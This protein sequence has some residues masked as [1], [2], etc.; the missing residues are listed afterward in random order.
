MFNM[1][2]W[3]LRSLVELYH[4]QSNGSPGGEFLITPQVRYMKESCSVKADCLLACSMFL[5]APNIK[6]ITIVQYELALETYKF[7]YD[8]T[9]LE[10]QQIIHSLGLRKDTCTLN[11]I[12]DNNIAR[13]V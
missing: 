9:N 12:C 2:T 3:Y 8:A 5:V 13:T 1:S 6:V 11:H 7:Q 10:K 4:R